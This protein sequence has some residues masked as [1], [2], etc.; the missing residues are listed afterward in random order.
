[1]DNQL[2]TIIDRMENAG[3]SQ[4]SIAEV[5]KAYGSKSGFKHV[6]SMRE[7]DRHE[8]PHDEAEEP[9]KTV[10]SQE[11]AIEESE[12]TAP[13][14]STTEDVTEDI[15]SDARPTEAVADVAKVDEEAL[16]KADPVAIGGKDQ[17]LINKITD[18][19]SEEAATNI[20]K[21]DGHLDYNNFGKSAD[22]SSN[23]EK[24][25]SKFLNQTHATDTYES[26]RPKFA[27]DYTRLDGQEAVVMK[28]LPDV[29]EDEMDDTTH[30]G[31]ADFYD[32]N[33]RYAG[34]EERTI[35]LPGKSQERGQGEGLG[36]SN[37]K[38]YSEYVE[39]VTGEKVDI[40][41]E[42][43]VK[44]AQAYQA[45]FFK[46]P[47]SEAD[48]RKEYE[49][50]IASGEIIKGADHTFDLLVEKVT[51]P[52]TGEVTT[53]ST[54]IDK[55]NFE[56]EAAEDAASFIDRITPINRDLGMWSKP[57][58]QRGVRGEK[59]HGFDQYI[60]QGDATEGLDFDAF[61]NVSEME[62]DGII[63][64]RV[65]YLDSGTPQYTYF[66]KGEGPQSYTL[67]QHDKS[68][69]NP[70]DAR[71][72]AKTE[73]TE[74]E[75]EVKI[76]DYEEASG[77]DIK[78]FN[79]NL[80]N[81]EEY[82]NVERLRADLL[83][84]DKIESTQEEVAVEYGV[85]EEKDISHSEDQE[86]QLE[87]EIQDIANTL[88][89]RPGNENKTEQE[90]LEMA[91]EEVRQY[92]PTEVSAN[93]QYRQDQQDNIENK[94][95][96]AYDKRVKDASMTIDEKTGEFI[97]FEEYKN[98][99]NAGE[100][101]II[102]DF[103]NEIQSWR[104]TQ[105][106]EFENGVNA[107]AE[108]HSEDI[109]NEVNAMFETELNDLRA[110]AK[111]ELDAKY[112]S[113][114]QEITTSIQKTVEDQLMQ[115]IKSG[116]LN[117]ESEEE[118]NEIFQQRVREGVEENEELA[119]LEA[120]YEKEQNSYFVDINKRY[121]EAYD[122]RM[123]VVLDPFVEKFTANFNAEYKELK[124]NYFN[125]WAPEKTMISKETFDTAYGA[126]NSSGF[127][128]M[129]SENK[130]AAIVGQWR[131]I[132]NS[133]IANQPDA[134][135]ADGN[136]RDDI[137]SDLT[138]MRREYDFAI[139][140]QLSLDA[141]GQS[142]QFA[143]RS[144]AQDC[145]NGLESEA[146][147][148]MKEA[149][150]EGGDWEDYL[151]DD[152]REA[153]ESAE[154]I[155]NAP[156]K[157][158]QNGA[159]NFY[160]GIASNDFI[161]YLP[162]VD[163]VRDLMDINYIKGI[164]DK[165]AK[166]VPLS[167]G[168]EQVLRMHVYKGMVDSKAA[169]MSNAYSAGKG[170][171]GSIK[172]M[173]DMALMFIP[174]GWA[175]K[176]TKAFLTAAT[177]QGVKNITKQG[178]KVAYRGVKSGMVQPSKA[179]NLAGTLS[180]IT[181]TSIA[182]TGRYIGEAQQAMTPE[183]QLAY[184]K[185]GDQWVEAI[186]A[187]SV[188]GDTFGAAFTRAYGKGWLEYGSEKFGAAL[189]GMSRTLMRTLS[190]TEMDDIGIRMMVGRYLKRF[191]IK[192]GT[193]K[194]LQ[195][196]KEIGG[197]DGLIGEMLEEIIVQPP[198]NLI[199][200]QG[201]FDGMDRDFFEQTSISVGAMQ[202]AFGTLGL[203]VNI[204]N[205]MQGKQS[206]SYNVD[207][208]EASNKAD[209]VEAVE[210][211][212]KNGE[213]T[214]DT[215]IEIDFDAEAEAEI[216]ALLK[217]TAA[218]HNVTYGRSGR[219]GAEITDVAA[220]IE[221]EAIESL[222]PEQRTEV[223]E[224]K[225]ELEKLKQERA[226]QSKKE[227]DLKKQGL[228]MAASAEAVTELNEKN[229]ERRN[230]INE[231]QA[232]VD[233]LIGP[234]VEAV[235]KARSTES[236]NNKLQAVKD[237]AGD[238][239]P[240]LDVV[241][242]EDGTEAAK[243]REIQMK[244][245]ALK[246]AKSNIRVSLNPETGVE[247]Y[248][249]TKTGKKLTLKQVQDSGVDIDT[250]NAEAQEFTN[251][252]KN[253]MTNVH[254]FVIDLGDGTEALVINKDA[255]LRL[256]REN[257]AAH[258]FLHRLLAKSFGA[259]P[260]TSL[261]VGKA[262]NKYIMNLNP[263]GIK[264]S[265]L[266]RRIAFYQK[267]Q[268]EVV[269]A[270]ETLNLFSDAIS[271]G[272]FQYNETI[273]TKI[274]DSI[275]RAARAVG[276]NVSFDDASDVFNFV[277][278]Y[279]KVMDGAA[280]G[281]K[282]A[283]LPLGMRR[284]MRRGVNIGGVIKKGSDAYNKYMQEVGYHTG[285]YSKSIGK[286]AEDKKYRES[287]DVAK[288]IE[289]YDDNHRKMVRKAAAQ[290]PDGRS[291]FEIDVRS[292]K[293][294]NTPALIESEFGQEI[295]P[296]VEATTKRLF[297]GIPTNIADE[298]GVSRRSFQNDLIAEASALVQ[299]E[300]DPSKQDIDKFI[301]NRLNLRA[302]N[303]AQRLGIA[304]ADQG[305]S[306]RLDQQ[307]EGRRQVDIAA[308][309]Q[310]MQDFET[311]D[312]SVRG[313]QEALDQTGPRKYVDTVG[314]DSKSIAEINQTVS[315]A[316][317]DIQG[318][319]YKDVKKLTT[320]V[321]APLSKVLD[322]TAEKF[323]IDP[324]R[325]VKP[326]DLNGAQRTSAQQY[327]SDNAEA[328]MDMLP[329]GETVSGVA[330]GVA[331]TKLGK[332]YEKGER[333][334]YAAGATAAGKATQTKRDF[335]KQEFL[336][337]FGVKE[338]GT[339]DNNKKHDGA[340][341]ALVNQAAMITANQALRE[342]AMATGSASEAAAASLADGRSQIMFSQEAVKEANRDVFNE[343]Y[344][345]LIEEVSE[346]NV[347]DLAS[348]EYAV[349]RVYRD[350][351]LTSREI[352]KIANSVY[353]QIQEFTRLNE[354][355]KGLG[356]KQVSFPTDLNK[357]LT[358]NWQG[359]QLE[360]SIMK[361]L[362]P[363]LPINKETGRPMSVGSFFTDKNRVERG[364]DAVVLLGNKMIESGVPAPQVAAIMLD[365]FGGMYSSATK[366]GDGR[367]ILDAE[368]KMI[369]DPEW[370]TRND[371]SPGNKWKRWNKGNIKKAPEGTKVGD[372]KLDDRGNKIHQDNRKQ[373]FFSKSDFVNQLTKIKGLESLK[374]G[375][376]RGQYKLN[377][378]VIPT[379]LLAEN[380]KS[381]YD[382][383]TG[384]IKGDDKVRF[385]ERKAQ[386]ETAR[387]SVE[388]ILDMYWEKVGDVDG[389][390]DYAD[391]AMV[392]T[393]LG[394]GMTSPLRRS[395]YFEYS[396]VGIEDVIKN[397]GN[398]SI[399]Q[400]TEYEHMK[401]Q[402]EVAVSILHS[403]LSTGS[404]D[405]KVWDG[406]KVAVI[407]KAMDTVLINNGYRRHSPI[408]GKP[409]YYNTKTFRDPNIQPLRSNDPSK[410]GKPAEFVG[411][412]FVE[413]GRALDKKGRLN[414]AE[415]Q[416]L[417]NAYD[418][419]KYSQE[420][421]KGGTVWDFD[422][423]LAHTKSNVIFTRDGET[424][425]V[426]AEKFATDGAALITEGW[427]PD[428]SE[429]NKV[430]G[431]TPGPM[432]DAAMD[433]A[434]KFGTKDTYILTARA[435]EAQVAIK[436]FLDALG[437]KIP[438]KNIVGLGNST[439]EAKASWIADNMI[440]KGYNDVYFA[441]DAMQNVEAVQ[442]MMDAL[443]V[444]GKAEQARIKFSQEGPTNFDNILEEGAAD[445]DSD[446]NM[447]L[448]EQSGVGRN[449][450]FS[451]A[452]A[453]QRGKNKGR[454]ILFLPPSARDFAGL[455]YSF[456]GK[457]K[458]GERHHA[459]FKKHLFDPF[460]KGI[461][462]LNALKHNVALEVRALKK[463]TPGINKV[464]KSTVP[465]TEFTFEQ[466]VRIY[467]WVK[468]GYEV[469]GLS[470]VDKAKLIKAIETLRPQGVD[471]KSFADGLAAII[472]Q[473][474]GLADPGANWLGGTVSSDIN[475]ALEG[476][477]ELALKQWIENKNIIF[478]EANLNKIEAI[479]GTRFR[480]ALE[481]MLYRMETGS[482]RS[483]G[484]S[485]LMNNFLHWINGSVGATMFFNARSAALQMIS[486]VNFINWSDN[487]V[488]AAAKAFA[489]QKQYW[490]DVAMIFNSPFLKQRRG[491]IGTDL[492]AAELLK[493]MQGSKNPM[494]TMIA[495]LLRIGFTPTQIA[496]SLAIATGGATMY[497]NRVNTYLNQGMSQ[498]DAEA[499]AFED[500]MEIA[501]ETQQS[502]RPD[503]IS[504]Q[505]ASPLGKLILAFQNTPM[506]Y[507]RLMRKAMLDWING[508]GDV[509]SHLSKIIY[510]GGVQSMIFYGLQSA[511]WS[512]LLGDDDEDDV[513]RKQQWVLNGMIDSILRGAGVGG[514]IVSS[515]KNTILEFMEQE[516]KANDGIYYTEPD[517]A[518]TL[519]EALNVS[520]PIGIKARKLYSSLQTWEFNRD[521]IKHMDKTDIDNPMY[522]AL[523]GAT[524]AVSNIPLSR[525]Y[526]KYQNIQEALNSD[527]EM[528][529]R[530]AMF[531]GWSRW[532]FGIKNQDVMTAKNEVK[533]I[534]AEER[535]E[536]QE[537]KKIERE[538]ERQAA[539]VEVIEE[540]K[541]DQQEKRDQGVDEKDITCAA[542]NK[543]GK[544]CGKKVLPG[545]SFCT[546]H[547]EVP[548]QAN[549][550]QCSHVKTNGDR[551]K[552]KTKNQSGKCYYHD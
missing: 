99:P 256:G 100:D 460:S 549:E 423:T 357:F 287:S 16:A 390:F 387:K 274:G 212:I 426:S 340:I 321:N 79:T 13:E 325:I 237:L 528:W 338:D 182:G 441:D 216:K 402:E 36:L 29:P 410:R 25:L 153:H 486:N 83:G 371:G 418:G 218:E 209:A 468:A 464:L 195:K 477:R 190:R 131:V 31:W 285:W 273:F 234:A 428:F 80:Y 282:K 3:E 89:E 320:G 54:P 172:M 21:R 316:K 442:D 69:Y 447:T 463:A 290:T 148:R 62:I 88:K 107:L 527:N 260:H 394:S 124:N 272:E 241:E 122:A 510:Y 201:L 118:L 543:S 297:D 250:I 360:T 350:T 230:R 379:G 47:V 311:Q 359:E 180:A 475:D 333:A 516:K 478:N 462:K 329:E 146:K 380:V 60:G 541:V 503:K 356:T 137:K 81:Y 377:N 110:T 342:N 509:K 157:M 2:A 431:G 493:D 384:K 57:R 165:Q 220:A 389:G 373:L 318:L 43:S 327:I 451:P 480:E 166:G 68:Y 355:H 326:S 453:R 78:A 219:M 254:G 185:V 252:P 119:Q 406:Y 244:N 411:K 213:I 499:K 23:K 142:S 126:L 152:E 545:Q 188:E 519:I 150:V 161:E 105:D 446:F 280:K 420:V 101:A 354:N 398:K 363:Y 32:N 30:P 386:A 257:V 192:P 278:D 522:D 529:K 506:Q 169:D 304:S 28:R 24:T 90:L 37:I 385:A 4:A 200:G 467:N 226:D 358:D 312:L 435:P 308:D 288:L 113:Q 84:D 239:D 160:N 362:G 334:R 96:K 540:H 15:S 295:M 548:Q 177:K 546:I 39:F 552:M 249:D 128:H 299:N 504:Q 391:F 164:A 344:P 10:D 409:R 138:K 332:F 495:H 473:T 53:R 544:R 535:E 120:Q 143:I 76:Y 262:L 92:T 472:E 268:G 461:R 497:R 6:I 141:E 429:F 339:F 46:G 445:L 98:L 381:I 35:I 314:Y 369:L 231:L 265:D 170:M 93:L 91:R 492:N 1:M 162:I 55:P 551:C 184:T 267:N 50:K 12:A 86:V 317:V 483:K 227:S 315:D 512:A 490:T 474:G 63:R 127:V 524:E 422:D 417:F 365:Y 500:M 374:P 97:S 94:L 233:A 45:T 112:G 345:D 147:R 301:S 114:Y 539:A 210:Y 454:W 484:Q 395:A 258:E 501:E 396:M 222:T 534:K 159:V 106:T 538:A 313:I 20:F 27:F 403:Y 351:N 275:R 130:R 348:I 307:V 229:A 115:E 183:M 293:H 518:Y 331:N 328:L 289:K 523:F 533:E 347:S 51:D 375:D 370:D 103:G 536:R 547:E 511:L 87:E 144:T 300:Y 372:L 532:S 337:A 174:A 376:V 264:D 104:V 221:I 38:A 458:T 236:Y 526:N 440:A 400:V 352:K 408:D 259:N 399:G 508:R 71:A 416:A 197:Y 270:E 163:D 59:I 330:T 513:E 404:L 425:I 507:N 52:K 434:G 139:W 224:K 11:G 455:I 413:A 382:E 56:A 368:G 470:E 243:F 14:E 444:K 469:P 294:G 121:N 457:G 476:A 465:G 179:I 438:A 194:A 44:D 407:S 111:K 140:N 175:S 228:P 134:Y 515:A 364:R 26:G 520:P 135:D 34:D 242:V 181:T 19:Q 136:L 494:K 261:A 306:V 319:G 349:E 427:T 7:E 246:K 108:A 151:N 361:V 397:K 95:K 336:E 271:S 309:D 421:P 215:M 72:W 253:N 191:G 277:R 73:N 419:I 424:M 145:I 487:N 129:N 412:N 266:R 40:S 61:T 378:S 415:K 323:G 284:A 238:L 449:K 537:Q 208:Y 245:D 482:T 167:N 202:L 414:H 498:A 173:G 82:M 176:G 298:A 154:Y 203:G 133:Y 70:F 171:P 263:D 204:K 18:G 17:A 279:N 489:N 156:E 132:E 521:V 283:K 123:D 452:K 232:D 199:D 436:E 149:G 383:K 9:G 496:D 186:K 450:T 488:L 286:D 310:A 502:A 517:H 102:E 49:A 74:V 401:P 255:S 225:A 206:S 324:K 292:D 116:E 33:P 471:I 505:Q 117:V 405:Q 322:T 77:E 269:S 305:A 388:Q 479:Y 303:L 155:L 491:G 367:F 168:E 296:I 48:K 343:R 196:L 281:K 456:L 439:G 542:V 530:V 187:T 8:H 525:L 223:E 393:S 207:G 430:T 353:S 251:D 335:T 109:T 217:G 214:E 531:M 392:I 158:S 41:K 42:Q 248:V 5:V 443:D 205:K 276:V 67:H 346:S 235:N 485:R 437:L 247:T 481:D 366:I 514:A 178:L 58:G 64:R 193:S 240:N 211:M 432:F 341:K 448:E 75:S 85:S 291:I 550:T 125:Q 189:P 466:A 65:G 459:W 433:K 198:Q 22:V 66:K 302:N